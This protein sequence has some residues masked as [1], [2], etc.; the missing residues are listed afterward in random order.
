MIF[1]HLPASLGSSIYRAHLGL[2]AG[3][4][5]AGRAVAAPSITPGSSFDINFSEWQSGGLHS[6]VRLHVSSLSP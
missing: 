2:E 4:G 1:L 6:L 3:D 5:A